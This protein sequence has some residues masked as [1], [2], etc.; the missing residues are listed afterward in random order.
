M[1]T[2]NIKLNFKSTSVLELNDSHLNTVV[3]GSPITD[4]IEVITRATTY[5]TWFDFV[6]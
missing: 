1:K 3:G 6:V 2:Q 4:A 5:G